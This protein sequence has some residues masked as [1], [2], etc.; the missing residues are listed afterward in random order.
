MP[1][2]GKKKPLFK[3]EKQRR[4][5]E[6]RDRDPQRRAEYLAKSRQKYETDKSA[7]ELIV[8]PP[9]S[10]DGSQ[11]E[12][13]N[14]HIPIPGPSN[15]LESPQNPGTSRQMQEARKN[16]AKKKSQCYRDNAKLE[17]K[18]D[19]LVKRVNI[20]K[21]KALLRNFSLPKTREK[22]RKQL[23]FNSALV[24]EIRKKYQKENL[25]RNTI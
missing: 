2:H 17:K 9:T 7:L 21:T 1:P 3:A 12:H 23:A 16:K 11:H 22:V 18:V 25:K 8:T 20:S 13:L 10:P 4:Y 14:D 6:R 5:P 24:E 19:N 15:R